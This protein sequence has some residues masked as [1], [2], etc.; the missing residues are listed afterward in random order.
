M[1]RQ[2]IIIAGALIAASSITASADE[3]KPV[4][5]LTATEFLKLPEDFQAVYIGGI[6]EGEAFIAYNYS[7]P[8]YSAWVACVRS[9]SFG[10]TTADV[11]AF[12]RAEPNFNG[13]VAYA[14]AKTFGN[15]CKQ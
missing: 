9:R 4:Q 10:D 1:G 15:R 3:T 2:C 6:I 13:T 5:G 12:L 8:N 14:L 7:M 11:V